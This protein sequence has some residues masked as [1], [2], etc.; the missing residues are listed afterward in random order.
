MAARQE[1]APGLVFADVLARFVAYLIDGFLIALVAGIIAEPM[2]WGV[3]PDAADPF[4]P[5]SFR[6][7]EYTILTAAIGALYF[8]ASWSGGRR[9]TLGQRLLKI[10]VGNAFD[11][12][13]LSFDQA[14]RRWLGLGEFLSLFGL[15]AGLAAL[16]SGVQLIWTIVLLITTASS[17]TKQGLHDRIANS[18]VVRPA[19]AG[20]GLVVACAVIAVV[21]AA[22]ALLSIIAL[23]FL[24]G[25]VSEILSEVGGSV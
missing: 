11:G 17:P 20:N 8:I 3:V 21:L 4:G 2:G 24:G 22:L 9:A 19:N 23:I 10:Q 16:A 7:T 18:A 15:T 6:T 5:E 14:V 12:R 25:Q 13:P 1:I